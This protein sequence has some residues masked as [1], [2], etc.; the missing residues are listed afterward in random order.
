MTLVFNSTQEQTN[1]VVF[2][3][4]IISPNILSN[5]WK[6]LPKDVPTTEKIMQQEDQYFLT[7]NHIFTDNHMQGKEPSFNSI[8]STKNP[9]NGTLRLVPWPFHKWLTWLKQNIW[10]PEIRILLEQHICRLT[11]LDQILCFL[12]PEGKSGSPFK[13]I[14]S[15]HCILWSVGSYHRR[16]CGPSFSHEFR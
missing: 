7:D 5:N 9:A 2:R 4:A 14:S 15:A 3:T 6:I 1:F 10:T 12:C 8:G 13:T 16:L 11:M